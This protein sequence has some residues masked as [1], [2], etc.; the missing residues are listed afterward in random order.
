MKLL[1][2][3]LTPGGPLTRPQK[4]VCGAQAGCGSQG[5]DMVVRGDNRMTYVC[6]AGEPPPLVRV[7]PVTALQPTGL[8]NRKGGPCR[9]GGWN[10]GEIS[11][12]EDL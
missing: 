10:G 7:S 2:G 8:H 9:G 1:G 11:S 6:F 5:S 12:Q 3:G 4:E